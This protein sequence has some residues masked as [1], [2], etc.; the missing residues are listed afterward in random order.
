[1][2]SFPPAFFFFCC[3]QLFG[4]TGRRLAGIYLSIFS[5]ISSRELNS[6]QTRIPI[7]GFFR[8]IV[9]VRLPAG[10][11][12]EDEPARSP[13]STPDSVVKPEQFFGISAGRWDSDA[14]AGRLP[15]GTVLFPRISHLF[16]IF[17]Y[18][19]PNIFRWRYVTHPSDCYIFEFF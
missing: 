9:R 11:R 10:S 15:A 2:P 8:T 12:S 18:L 19:N 13:A 1:M 5:F 7:W 17:D 14:N 16:A 3:E 4:L 6:P